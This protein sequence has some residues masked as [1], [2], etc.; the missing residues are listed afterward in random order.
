MRHFSQIKIRQ[1][2]V[3]VHKNFLQ[4]HYFFSKLITSF[5]NLNFS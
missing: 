5:I 1:K 2:V 3:A 4:L